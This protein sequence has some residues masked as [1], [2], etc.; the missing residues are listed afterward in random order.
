[1]ERLPSGLL[2]VLPCCI[3]DAGLALCLEFIIPCLTLIA[4]CVPLCLMTKEPIIGILILSRLSGANP[5]V[6]SVNMEPGI[7]VG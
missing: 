1:M 2:K 5:I 4:D 3:Q 7:E 6:G